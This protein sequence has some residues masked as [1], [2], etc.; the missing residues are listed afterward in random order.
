LLE[1]STDTAAAKRALVRTYNTPAYA[2][3]WDCIEDFER[4]QAQ[5]AKHPNKGPAALASVVDLP[6]GRIRP[7][8]GGSQPDCCRGLQTALSKS[9]I[10]EKWTDGGR[11]LNCLAAWTLSSGGID[12]HWV[13]QWVAPSEAEYVA[14][15]EY[16]SAV[17]V[18]LV[19][20]RPEGTTTPEG[21]RRAAEYRPDKDASV[22]GRVLSTWTGLQGD[23][24]HTVRFPQYV[25]FAPDEV[26]RDFC[27][28]YVAQRGVEREHGSDFTQISATRSERFRRDLLDQLRRVVDEPDAVRG[29][30]GPCG[31]TSPRNRSQLG[32]PTSTP[33]ETGWCTVTGVA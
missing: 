18:S 22:L 16:A 5:A 10:I 12:G 20:T 9:W 26:A 15:E 4:V 8:L 1:N 29:E 23:K 13:P 17:G 6:R 21:T 14:L 33:S 2:D 24:D 28:V 32:I 31:F 3:P 11:A 25:R 27:R 30:S 7:W 19:Q